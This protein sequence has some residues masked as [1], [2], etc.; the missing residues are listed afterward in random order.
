MIRADSVRTSAP[1]RKIY[2]SVH[3]VNVDMQCFTVRLSHSEDNMMDRGLLLYT[4]KNKEK[5]RPISK[6]S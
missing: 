3:V 5:D 6:G 4:D 1:S 2:I